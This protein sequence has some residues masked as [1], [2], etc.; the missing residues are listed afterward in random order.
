MITNGQEYNL[1]FKI[2]KTFFPVGFKGIDRDDTLL[3]DLEDLMK[4]NNQFFF[5][6]GIDWFKN[7]NYGYHNYAGNDMSNFRYPDEEL[8]ITY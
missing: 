8:L 7:L 1:F 5:I 6:T 3:S 2:I 4:C